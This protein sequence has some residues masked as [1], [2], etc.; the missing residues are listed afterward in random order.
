MP[1]QLPNPLWFLVEG[2]TQG[3]VENALRQT[4]RNII[5]YDKEMYRDKPSLVVGGAA[6][7]GATADPFVTSVAGGVTQTVTKVPTAGDGVAGYVNITAPSSVAQEDDYTHTPKRYIPKIDTI[8]EWWDGEDVGEAM[9]ITATLVNGSAEI[10]VPNSELLTPGQKITGTN[11]PADTIILS[12]IRQTN[13]V[14]DATKA[15]MS[16]KATGSGDTT[17]TLSGSNKVAECM[18]SEFI[19]WCSQ[20]S[21]PI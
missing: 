9:V 12:T 11:I 4:R 10:T 15:I 19:D 13:G 17:A 1:G 21:I 6:L 20:N 8:I 5:V 16:Q 2:G 7:V 18:Q 3:K 14:I